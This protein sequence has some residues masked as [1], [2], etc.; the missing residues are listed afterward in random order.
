MSRIVVTHGIPDEGLCLLAGHEVIIPPPLTAFSRAELTHLLADADAVL[1]CGAIDAEMLRGASRLKIVAN[2]GAGYDSVDVAAAA[3]CG[4]PV[5][6]IP[7][8]TADATA[9]LAAGLMLAVSRRIGEM[10]LRLRREAPETLFGVGREMGRTLRGMTLGILGVGRIGGRMGEIGK[11]LGM[12]VIGY[13]RRGADPA[14]AEPVSF[15][16]LLAQSDVLSVHCPLTP[17]TRGLVGA[18]AIARMKPGAILINTAR[19]GV[20]DTDALVAA[21]KAGRLS[22][23]GLDV[24]PDEPHVPACLLELDNVVLTPHVGTNTAQTRCQMA[25]ACCRQIL[26]ALAGRRPA[27]IVNGL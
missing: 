11:A 25:E 3:A 6:N 7:E 22:G 21:L 20:V 12:R 26:D 23:A 1:A 24:Y 14:V 5:T 2:Y 27:N 15:H 18:E 10:T 13:S 19:G 9:E 16:E 4:V 8:Q 17:A